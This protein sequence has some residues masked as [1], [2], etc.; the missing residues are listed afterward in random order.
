MAVESKASGHFLLLTISC[1]TANLP[2]DRIRP[3][4]NHQQV[5][6]AD[7]HIGEGE[8]LLNSW[9]ASINSQQL[10]LAH[11]SSNTS[12][13]RCV[14]AQ[15]AD[16][17]TSLTCIEPDSTTG[18]SKAVI[19]DHLSLVHT[20]QILPVDRQGQIVPGGLSNQTQQVLASLR[21]V[22]GSAR[23]DLETVAKLN[24]YISPSNAISVVSQALARE[25]SHANKPAATFV[26]TLLPNPAARVAMDAVAV[27]HVQSKPSKVEWISP[28]GHQD[29]E[30]IPAA[31]PPPGP[32]IYVSG[33]ADTNHL[34]DD[35]AGN[36]LN[37]I[38]AEFFNPLRP[39]A[40]SKAK[41]RGV[42]VADKTITVDMIAVTK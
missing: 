16:P 24:V 39:P 13:N 14:F 11:A 12:H 17:A 9:L 8:Q 27:P 1:H 4:G 3:P 30:I 21:A 28:L 20:T 7:Y 6:S 22:L 2:V 15:H 42:A 38:R 34:S 31:M 32:L 10:N 26:V 25:F 41:V 40:A 23:C 37:D 35:F 36:K 33:M 5:R 29:R 19:A 18:T